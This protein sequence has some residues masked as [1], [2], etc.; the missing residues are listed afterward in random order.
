MGEFL[1][2][3]LLVPVVL[4]ALSIGCG[5]LVAAAAERTGA[6]RGEPFPGALLMPVGFAA[7]VTLAAFV[8]TWKATAPLAGVLPAVVAAVGFVV[9]RGRIAAWWSA[10]RSVLWP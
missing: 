10:K 5:L 1:Q 7:V 4:C 3:W 9:G 6:P 2:S 8:T